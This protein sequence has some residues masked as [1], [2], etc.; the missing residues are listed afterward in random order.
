MDFKIYRKSQAF[1]FLFFVISISGN[2][3]RVSEV[4]GGV[5]QPA[6]LLATHAA[7]RVLSYGFLFFVISISGDPV[8]V[9]EVQ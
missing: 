4:R 6:G 7:Q 2:P 5:G 3:V 1:G 9:P 8:P